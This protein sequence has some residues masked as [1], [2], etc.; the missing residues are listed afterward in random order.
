MLSS[1]TVRRTFHRSFSEISDIP[2]LALG[3]GL[4]L[5]GVMR[6]LGRAKVPLYSVCSETDYSVH[7]RWYHEPPLKGAHDLAPRELEL[8]LRSLPLERAVLMPCADD[9]LQA[10]A[11]LPASLKERFPSSLSPQTTVRTMVDKWRFAQLLEASQIPHPRTL[12]LASLQQLQDLPETD[13][14]TFIL[15]PLVSQEFLREHGVKGYIVAN[16][17]EALRIAASVRFPIMLQEYIPGP[18]TASFFVDGFVDRHGAICARFARQRLRIYPAGLGNSSLMVSISLNEVGAA[19][20][21]L[22]HLLGSIPYRGIFCAE[23]KF[24]VR[25]GLFKILEI[26]ARPWWYI[27]FAARCGV[28]VCRL[29]YLD[30]LQLPVEPI[31][32]YQVGRY[33]VHL[34]T[35]YQAY[36]ELRSSHAINLFSWIRSWA[37]ADDALFVWD[38]LGPAMASASH[39]LRN[40]IHRI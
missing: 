24:D 22:D 13:S 16:R 39:S 30:A 34:A 17:A 26:N 19:V 8:F 21:T 28:D 37:G 9:W 10:V 14:G 6:I 4:T 31:Q 27:E 25:D 20:S 23:F 1:P 2:V 18:P 3:R 38:D 32:N 33:C 15:K 35:D 12:L 5:T 40:L 36:H 7:S 11:D 29:A